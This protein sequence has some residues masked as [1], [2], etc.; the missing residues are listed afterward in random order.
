MRMRVERR[1]GSRECEA[2]GG[3]AV[4]RAVMHPGSPRANTPACPLVCDLRPGK[5]SSRQPILSPK[6]AFTSRRAA[7]C[8]WPSGSIPKYYWTQNVRSWTASPRPGRFPAVQGALLFDQ[9]VREHGR[10]VLLHPL[11]KKHR[12]FLAE[13]GG[14]AETREFIALERGS[15]SRAKELPRGLGLGKGHIGLLGNNN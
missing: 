2:L 15:R 6:I 5:F 9:P 12:D 3:S 13:I 11:V 10:R 8:V 14:M 1:D 7:I 4:A